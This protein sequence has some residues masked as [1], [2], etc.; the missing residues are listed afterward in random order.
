MLARAGERA[1]S[2]AAAAEARRYFEQA[3]ELTDDPPERA[4]LL[5][6]A[7]EMAARAGDPDA[8][9]GSSRS[10][11]SSTRPRR[12]ACRRP[13]LWRLARVERITGR[14]DEA[15]ARMERAFDVISADEPDE[16]L[17]LLAGRLSLGYFGTA[18]SSVASERA[19]LALD[20]AEAHRYP[21][22][23]ALALRAKAG[24][25]HS[26][27]HTEEAGALLK[28]ISGDRARARPRR[29]GGQLLLQPL[30]PV[31]PA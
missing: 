12:H 27:G 14:R 18:T 6:S 29:P 11:S 1:E 4:A 7:G 3:A 17:A 23:L 16:D 9:R 20:I 25:A 24:V 10:R 28:R 2:L 19:E 26:R 30:R 15:L 22:A 31:L 13:R 5:G 8:A 21:E